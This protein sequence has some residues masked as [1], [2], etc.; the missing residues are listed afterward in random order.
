MSDPWE[1]FAA[2]ISAPAGT[3]IY[4]AMAEQIQVP[5]IVIVP[6]DPWVT[7]QGYSY[8][9]ERYLAICLVETTA[10]QDGLAKLQ[11]LVH[12]VR[13]AGGEG[14]EIHDAS[15]VRQARIP[16]DG[17]QYLGSWIHVSFR[18]CTHSAEE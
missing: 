10:P 3:N 9:D 1:D 14:W 16:D 11:S 18:D 7:S 17:S 2:R 4:P 15:G 8:D 13:E 12:A 5:A 6:D